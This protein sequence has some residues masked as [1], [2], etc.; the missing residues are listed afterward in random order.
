MNK[1]TEAQTRRAPHV[2]ARGK[3]HL[4]TER[5]AWA[6]WGTAAVFMSLAA[7]FAVLSRHTP[8][9]DW[10]P[11]WLILAETPLGLLLPS[12]GLLVA[13]RVPNNPAGWL[14]LVAGCGDS[15]DLLSHAYALHALPRGLPGGLLSA[16][17]SS[18]SFALFTFPFIFLLLL[19]PNGHVPSARW[20]WAARYMV[21]C[22]CVNL[23]IA[24]TES[25]PL[26]GGYFPTTTN[27][28][29]IPGLSYSDV[30]IGMISLAITLV[31]FLLSITALLFRYR[32]VTGQEK[33]QLKWMAW[34]AL[35][36][37]CL[38]AAHI[39]LLDG[40]AESLAVEAVIL[41]LS[42]AI[43]V[44]IV[45]DNLFDI[46]RILSHTLVYTGLTGGVIGLYVG[47]VSVLGQLLRHS[48]TGAVPLLATGIV[49]VL[50]QPLRTLLQRSVSRLV[51]GLRDDPYTALVMLGRRLET[52][53]DPQKVLPEAAA[54]VAD[55][56]H[57]P[58]V[59]IELDQTTTT[60]VQRTRVAAHG[61][62][63][64]PL[65]ELILVHRGEEIGVLLV[66]ARDAKEHF[67]SADMRL[68]GDVARHIAQ[69]ASVVQLSLTLGQA[70]ERAVAAAAEE[71]RRLARDLHDGVGP[72]L[73]GATW[74][75]QAALTKL[76]G[77]PDA[78]Q[79]LL[80]TALDHIRRGTEDLRRISVGLRS[81]A[82][83]LG[84]R[85]AVLA[86]LERVPLTTD[87]RFSD[88]PLRLPAAVEEAAYWI[89]AEAVGNTVRHARAD[90]CWVSVASGEA[91][92]LTVADDGCGLPELFR[93]GVGLGSMRE[94]AAEIG[95]T[96]DVRTRDGGG[97]EV[98]AR[99]PLTLLGT[100][101]QD[102]D[103][104]AK[105]G[106]T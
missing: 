15:I 96:C 54:V 72:V 97:T 105:G 79:D 106:T 19:F 60:G 20:R 41:L 76:R 34:A 67:S 90:T 21:A 29:G 73:T 69:A 61:T 33:R 95:G 35:V 70:Q 55:A 104:V 10:H 80:T 49:A 51:Y 23:L 46:D 44:A 26:G 103:L 92:V 22:G 99:L 102:D 12:L 47:A 56:L 8:R 71:R 40:P 63:V 37:I 43:T 6:L 5:T 32:S 53:S 82:D 57:V 38:V 7:V 13:R 74:T 93:P 16:W 64:R 100:A 94:R 2:V 31:P 11:W 78:T 86:Y 62:E 4:A 88:G 98:V 45:R 75:L 68:L 39:V 18:W 24:A 27:P 14:L 58:Y 101:T 28:L 65:L 48:A 30:T 83:Q 36:G 87:V 66:G 3:A 25:G 52:T 42:T 77:D 84:L 50:L 17:V 91:L 59:A 85:D 9:P 1:L 81:P 89:I